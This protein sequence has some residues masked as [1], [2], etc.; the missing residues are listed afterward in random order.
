MLSEL[1]EKEK[2]A[3]LKR[4]FTAA[5]TVSTTA[6]FHDKRAYYKNTRAIPKQTTIPQYHQRDKRV[7]LPSSARSVHFRS[8]RAERGW[9]NPNVFQV[10]TLMS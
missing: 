3:E 7:L 6:I 1:L 5:W 8:L 10:C 2:Y 9:D 4:R